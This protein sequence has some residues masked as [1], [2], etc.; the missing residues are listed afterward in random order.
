MQSAF[1]VKGSTAKIFLPRITKGRKLLLGLIGIN[2]MSGVSHSN[3]AHIMK[4]PPGARHGLDFNIDIDGRCL[5]VETVPD[6]L[7]KRLDRTLLSIL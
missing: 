3:P 1:V 5:S 2:A 7:T 4:F 6:E